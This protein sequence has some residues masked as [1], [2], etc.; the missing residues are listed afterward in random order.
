M[1]DGKIYAYTSVRITNIALLELQSNS[2]H[3]F[4]VVDRII[5]KPIANADV[6]LRSIITHS[7]D[8]EIN[9]HQTTD[10]NG[11]VIKRTMCR[12]FSIER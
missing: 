4:Q 9:E 6:H 10:K 1:P 7:N 2:L 3:R 8:A 11:I 12:R 5:G